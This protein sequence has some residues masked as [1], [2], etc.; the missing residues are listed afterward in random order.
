MSHRVIDKFSIEKFV[1]LVYLNV[2]E[3]QAELS[4]MNV[5]TASCFLF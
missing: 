4:N 1:K 3:K 2:G 5:R